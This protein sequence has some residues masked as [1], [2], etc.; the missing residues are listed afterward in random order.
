MK[1]RFQF[2]L[3]A[4]IAIVI[5]AAILRSQM[6]KFDKESAPQL[7]ATA[8]YAC[9]N[10]RNILVEFYEATGTASVA[11]PGEQPV[12]TGSA[13]ITLSDGRV[14]S[15]PQTI[16]ADG[17]R[18]ANASSSFVFWSKG[19]GA[20]VLENNAPKTYTGCITVKTNPGGLSQVYQNSA[21]SFTVRYPIGFIPEASYTYTNLGPKKTIHGIK[22]A[23]PASMAAGTNLSPDSY[24]SIEEIP[25]TTTCSAE[26]FVQKGAKAISFTENGTEYSIATSSD[27]GAG[28]RYE[29]TIYA[30]PGTNPCVATRYFI[31]YGAYE[32]YPPGTVAQFDRE[33]I[34]GIFDKIRRTLTISQ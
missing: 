33:A 27:A 34:L 6:P 32:N 26:L 24:V 5:I 25:K 29:E 2:V 18:Y 1:N 28:N 19:N 4:A 21:Q 16:S 8:E 23:M 12:P 3:I 30:F 13:L 15:L 22:L 7:I 14:F 17:G 31:H 10:S 11:K 20:L 9:N